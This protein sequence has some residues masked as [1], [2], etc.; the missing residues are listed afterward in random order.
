MQ[1]FLFLMAVAIMIIVK[2]L[3]KTDKRENLASNLTLM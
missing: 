3:L 2:D 1:A